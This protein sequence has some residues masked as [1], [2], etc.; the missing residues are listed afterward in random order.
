MAV[1]AK[2]QHLGERWRIVFE[3]GHYFA[4]DARGSD[5]GPY[6]SAAQ[7]REWI[8]AIVPA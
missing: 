3:G 8:K 7:A 1:V 2:V 4:R 5:T 6:S